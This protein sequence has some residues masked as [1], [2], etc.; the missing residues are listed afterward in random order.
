M[1]PTKSGRREPLPLVGLC[2]FD[3]GLVLHQNVGQFGIGVNTMAKAQHDKVPKKRGR[4]RLEKIHARYE[5][6]ITSWDF[7]WSFYLSGPTDR[8][9]GRS[10]FREV[11]TLIL[12]G[13]VLEPEGFKYPEALLRIVADPWLDSLVEQ[14]AAI[15]SIHINGRKFTGYV[16]IPS[17]QMPLL[18][19]SANRLLFVELFG[20]PLRFR[21]ALIN[22][23]HL[24]TAPD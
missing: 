13:R 14:P 12:T 6:Q 18:V 5:I 15:G 7:S 3:S 21:K 10:H 4:P 23:L 1:S 19:S 20:T 22:E 16:P 9:Q 24:N 17:N 2:R 8:W 11:A